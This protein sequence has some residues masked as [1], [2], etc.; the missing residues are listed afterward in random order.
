[1]KITLAILSLLFI[2]SAYSQYE[3]LSELL[4]PENPK[5]LGREGFKKKKEKFLHSESLVT[6]MNSELGIQEEAYYTGF[7][8]SRLSISVHASSDYES[9]NEL[10][11][12]DVQYFNRV[13]SMVNA[14]WA[15]QYK[16]TNANFDAIAQNQVRSIDDDPNAESQYE[17]DTD[18]IS[19]LA[20][21]GIGVAHRFR[22]LTLFTGDKSDNFLE[23][24]SA[25]LN[26]TTYSDTVV[27]DPYQGYSASMEYGFHRRSRS[28]IF[29]GGKLSYN[30]GSVTREQKGKEEF[31][32]RTVTFGWTSLAFELGYYY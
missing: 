20:M 3:D 22:F 4:V 23:M 12:F 27:E 11:S 5:D 8:Q 2:S 13:D 19:T 14:W 1:M 7:D 15:L 32:E 21:Y 17:R 30:I 6:D 24:V 29:F 25:F 18:D 16:F 26:Y 9:F 28:R 31:K 10:S